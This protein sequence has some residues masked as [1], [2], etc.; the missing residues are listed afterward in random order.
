[1]QTQQASSSKPVLDSK[2]K[3]TLV[4]EEYFVLLKFYED[5]DARLLTIKGWSITAGMA[6]IGLGLQNSKPLLCLFGSGVAILFWLLEATWKGL[7]HSYGPRIAEIEAAYR[8]G[9]LDTLIPLQAHT[10]WASNWKRSLRYFKRNVYR[11]IVALPH[12]ITAI[13]GL[14]LYR[15]WTFVV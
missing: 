10:N 5:F 2:D 12:A 11:P 9:T 4:K 13:A 15:Y 14:L 7:Q 8:S 6:A 3:L 1:M